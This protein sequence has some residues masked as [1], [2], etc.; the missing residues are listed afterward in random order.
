[1]S[2]VD[3]LI[4]ELGTVDNTVCIV[5]FQIGDDIGDGIG[6]LLDT[7]LVHVTKQGRD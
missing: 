3:R 4:W 6:V 2:L 7:T 1:L 5:K